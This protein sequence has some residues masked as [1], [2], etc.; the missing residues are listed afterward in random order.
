MFWLNVEIAPPSVCRSNYY[1]SKPFCYFRASVLFIFSLQHVNSYRYNGNLLELFSVSWN[2]RRNSLFLHFMSWLFK[3]FLIPTRYGI[4]HSF[5]SFRQT[6]WNWNNRAFSFM[7]WKYKN[8]SSSTRSYYKQNISIILKRK[9]L[10]LWKSDSGISFV[11][12]LGHLALFV[13]KKGKDQTKVR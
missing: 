6:E 5:L 13:V 9:L 7:F 10:I 2:P 3:K 4:T 8:I 12:R 11:L 1:V